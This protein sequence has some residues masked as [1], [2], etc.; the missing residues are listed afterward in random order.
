MLFCKQAS[1]A[2]SLLWRLLRL[3]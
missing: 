2:T 3:Y 1:L